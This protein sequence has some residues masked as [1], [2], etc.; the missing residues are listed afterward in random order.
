MTIQSSKTQQIIIISVALCFAIIYFV[1]FDFLRFNQADTPNFVN[2]AKILFGA[3]GITENQSRITKPF[4]L[5]VPGFLFTYAG[6]SITA[7]MLVQNILFFVATGFLTARLLALWKYSFGMQ[8]LGVFVL[9]TVQPIAV[10]SFMLINDIA[11]FFFTTLILYVYFLSAHIP[12][13][14]SHYVL[15]GSLCIA[16]I[17]SKESSGLALIVI[18]LHTALHERYRI[19]KLLITYGF[20]ALV[21]II[22]QLI[23]SHRY[24]YITSIENVAEKYQEPEGYIF[25]IQQLIH[26]FDMYWLYICIGIVYIV[27]TRVS[28]FFVW[29]ALVTIPLLFIWPSVQ[30]RTIAVAAPVFLWIIVAY[31]AQAST[32]HRV[33]LIATGVA[34]VVV[35]YVIYAHQVS[36]LLPLL[37]CICTSIFVGISLWEW[38]TKKTRI[39][40]I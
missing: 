26:S 24:G 1:L 29:A 19:G 23:I 10:L 31:M 36:L 25:K 14:I 39:E 34:Q 21:Y 16:G 5:L 15:L 7:T 13:T 12:R 11:G 2:A 28:L 37:Y 27:R 30:D 35:S 40:G 3:E 6:V 33:L 20:V 38:N 8:L 17:L 22:V 18:A 9:Y 32:A 4:V